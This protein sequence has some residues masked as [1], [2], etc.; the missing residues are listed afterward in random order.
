MVKSV[1]KS[2]SMFGINDCNKPRKNT[3]KN[4]TFKKRKEKLNKTIRKKSRPYNYKTI[5]LFP[6]SLGQTKLGTEKAPKY[7]EKYINHGKHKVRIVKNTGNMFRNINDLYKVNRDTKG[8]IVNIGGDHSMAIATIADT[9]NKYP[10]AKVVYFDA[11]ADLNTYKSS[12][13]KHYHGMPLSFVTGLDKD[14]R[15]SFIKNK[16]P[17]E[18]ILYIGSRCWDPFEIKEVYK[19]NIKFL[20]PDDINNNFEDSLN[21]IM[22]FVGDSPVHVSFDVDS[23]DPE[24]IPSTGTP[25]KNGV[26]LEKAITILDNLNK[27]NMVNLDITELNTNLGNK[28]DG[29]KSLKNTERLFHKFIM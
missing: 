10:N 28:K 27:D 12:N 11:H 4:Y 15:F 22:N 21:R 3:K 24:Y 29:H 17:F 26:E 7:L 9:L 16:L 13:S 18:N 5:I 2:V 8:K 6:H 14:K 20:M 1:K 25:V 19:H 23:I